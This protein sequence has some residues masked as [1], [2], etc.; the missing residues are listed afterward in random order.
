MSFFLTSIYDHSVF[1]AF[2][3]VS[4]GQKKE[5]GGGPMRHALSLCLGGPMRMM[6]PPPALYLHL[7]RPHTTG[8]AAPHPAAPDAREPAQLPHLGLQDGGECVN[9]NRS[10]VRVLE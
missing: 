10:F 8:G 6:A 9:G 2:S 7:T 1:E 3:K 4:G 5:R